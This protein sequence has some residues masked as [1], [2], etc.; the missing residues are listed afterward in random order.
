MG[1]WSIGVIGVLLPCVVQAQSPAGPSSVSALHATY[2]T[3]AAGLPVAEVQSGFSFGLSDYQMTLA[4][5]TTG[6][7]GFLFHGRQRDQVNGS[8]QGTRADPSR[9]VGQG[10][11]HGIDRLTEIDYQQHQPIIRQLVPPNTNERQPVPTSLQDHTIDT[12]SAL[13]QL[14]H[15]VAKTGRC[16]TT[17]RTYD[18][19]R[20]V[21]IEA[22]TIGQETLEPTS[23]SSFT[24]SALRCD[25][26]GQMLSGFKFG[27]DPVND[28]KPMHGSA[29][30]ASVTANGPPLPVRLA[31][32]T[33]WF[34]D[35]MMYLT[36]T[37]PGAELKVAAEP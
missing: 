18:G 19:R 27:D 14:I 20:A 23:R 24:G 8:W 35:A 2:T 26:S 15:V 11:W 3:Y 9:F 32:Q 30:L 16:E 21:Q 5:H 7:A 6:I 4:Y 37:G 22:H 31:F 36:S 1:R 10:E 12:L 17:V 29:W 25:F 34:G 33:R 13:A 28:S